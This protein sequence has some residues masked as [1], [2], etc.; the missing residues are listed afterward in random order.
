MTIRGKWR[1]VELPDYE[2]DYADMMEPAYILLE[3]EGAGE[4]AF[5]CVTGQILNAGDG[6][7]VEFSWT[8]NDEMDEAFGTGWAER[9]PDGSLK[10]EICFHRGDDIEFIARPWTDSSTAC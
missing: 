6:N 3:D 9:Q 10:G 7:A 1:I 8:G 5:G 2:P 4:F